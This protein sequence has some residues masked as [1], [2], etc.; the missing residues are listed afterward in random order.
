[1]KKFLF[2]LAALLMAGSL[3][4]EEYLYIED[5][6][7]TQDQL[8]K[9]ITVP[10]KAHFE[11][12]VSAAQVNLTIPEGMVLRKI[13]KGSSITNLTYVDDYGD[14]WTADNTIFT[15]AVA[16]SNFAFATVDK[17]YY[18]VDGEWVA[19]GAVKF[20]PG[21]YD[22]MAVLT[23]RVNAEFTGG[24]IVVETMP[25]CGNDARPD[26]VCCE[27]DQDNFMT[28][29]VTVEGVEPQLQDLAGTI[30]IA[31]EPTEDGLLAIAYDGTEDV[32]IVVTVNGEVVELV[33]GMVQLA[34]GEN[35]IVVTVSAEGYN[36]LVATANVT[37][38]PVPPTP[39]TAA[40]V[41]N[42]TEGA[43]EYIIEAVGEGTVILY[44]N[45]AEVENPCT[46][47]RGENDVTYTFTATAQAPGELLSEVY[48]LVVVVPAKEV[49]PEPDEH[50]VGY[51]LVLVEHDGNLNWIKLVEGAN[52]EYT[53]AYDVTYPLHWDFGHFYYMIN[54]VPYG[55][56][57]DE[58][59]AVFGYANA[60]PLTADCT[61]TYTVPVG[62]R[63]QIGLNFII[64]QETD[65][66][67]GYAA[68][69]AQGNPVS[70]DELVNGKTVAG[71]RY[72]NMA[73][74]EMQEANGMTIVVTTYTDGTTSAVKVMK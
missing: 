59:E 34:E 42:V 20:M 45:G 4:A 10:I 12:A 69:V 17:G 13:D 28:C 57:E 21:E 38:A 53:T 43:E 3:C 9:N 74:Q 23:I 33:D 65:E 68:Y 48:E 70:V 15:P 56:E 44:C 31:P 18:E 30:S 66:L 36:D 50:M 24:E 55:A 40:P 61:N 39:Q 37:Y 71:V 41:I 49:G 27:K 64:D 6:Q 35:N 25:A 58:T 67:V 51:W 72:F 14:E 60:N 29:V 22:E 1:M 19:Y 26:V 47:V 8:G 2:T 73:G 11:A 63:Y 16:T 62:Y 46:I 32:T 7:V 54:G 5:F 52:T